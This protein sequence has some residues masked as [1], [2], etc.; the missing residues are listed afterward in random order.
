MGGFE[1]TDDLR[2]EIEA[3]FCNATTHFDV[4]EL[5][6][7]LLYTIKDQLDK[8]HVELQNGITLKEFDGDDN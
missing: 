6:A 3:A 4:S 8:R 1:M 7:E 2:L 5:Y